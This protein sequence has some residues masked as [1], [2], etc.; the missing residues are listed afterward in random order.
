MVTESVN[1]QRPFRRIEKVAEPSNLF[2]VL[3]LTGWL[4]IS[5]LTYLSLSLPYD[6]FEPSYLAHN[7]GQSVVGMVVS[8]P[9]RYVFRWSWEWSLWSRA[10]LVVLATSILSI[11]WTVLRLEMFILMTRERTD[12]WADRKSVV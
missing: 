1:H 11:F 10:L 12:L 2:W 9:L 5:L 8:L 7:I 6:Q 3:H 4:G